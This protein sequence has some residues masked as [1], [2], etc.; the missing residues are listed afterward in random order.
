MRRINGVLVRVAVSIVVG[1]G[2]VW[3]SAAMAATVSTVTT[4]QGGLDGLEV[5]PDGAVY[6]SQPNFN[7]VYRL[8]DGQVETFLT[9][10]EFP[11]GTV[12]DDAENFYVSSSTRVVQ[13]SPDGQT[14]DYANGF[15][16]A[17][18]LVF[19]SA[20]NLFVADYNLSQIFQVTP[21][22]SVTVF[23]QGDELNGPA[24]VA[25]DSQGRLYAGNFNDGKIIRF[26]STGE[27]TLIAKPGNR[28]GY[29]AIGNDTIYATLG[30]N[31]VIT[32]S[33]DGT[34]TPLAGTGQN[35]SV[36]GDAADATFLGTNGITVSPDLQTVYV[37]E[38]QNGGGVRAIAL[39]NAAAF[40]IN[41][42]VSGAW[43][44]PVTTG[45]GL[46]LDVNP[47]TG[48]F[49]AAWFTYASDAQGA[50]GTS[51]WFTASG[52]YVGN[53]ADTVIFEST[54]GRF[55]ADRA[56]DTVPVG[57]M[58]FE[59]SDCNNASVSYAFDAGTTGAFPI[60]RVI[61]GTETLCEALIPAS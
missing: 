59:F 13:R 43:F 2:L 19:D 40:D 18:G 35:G 33:L 51:R 54:G 26:S 52:D 8:I 34:V 20:G 41:Q 5:G 11:L 42:G 17:A 24:G 15:S 50:D 31:R 48:F 16:L 45:S 25:F 29:I 1:L 36:D 46:L 28:V 21:G 10:L 58:Q 53:A 47:D 32:V 12:F 44:Y 30:V 37:S 14:T 7:R 4:G 38:F 56:V 6:V 55:D 49:F 3:G 60:T 9:G 23:A 22:G 61:P 57:T 27:Q 39:D